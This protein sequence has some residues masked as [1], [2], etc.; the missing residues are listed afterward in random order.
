MKI[1]HKEGVQSRFV[2]LGFVLWPIV[3]YVLFGL[4]GSAVF[5]LVAFLIDLI[6]PKWAVELEWADV[7]RI[8]ANMEAMS[9]VGAKGFFIF[10]KGS[11]YVI[12]VGLPSGRAVLALSF[13][14]AEW[15]QCDIDRVRT[16]A[17]VQKEVLE[18]KPDRVYLV[19][20]KTVAVTEILEEFIKF[21][22]LKLDD[23]K[24]HVNYAKGNVYR[25]EVINASK[26]S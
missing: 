20:R 23:C 2:T 24:I 1:Q 21:N 15:P 16:G 14:P 19:E 17:I 13:L 26:D 25:D 22:R 18:G 11:F 8:C 4:W 12:K 10:P 9:P 6:L 7:S 5:L 3:G